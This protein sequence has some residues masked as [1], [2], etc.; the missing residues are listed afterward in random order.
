MVREGSATVNT[1]EPID[2]MLGIVY[3][4]EAGEV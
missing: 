4:G 3:L 2:A 1:E